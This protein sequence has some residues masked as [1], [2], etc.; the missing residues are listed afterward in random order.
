MLRLSA[1]MLGREPQWEGTSAPIHAAWDWVPGGN[2][3][4]TV[5][6]PA[7]PSEFAVFCELAVQAMAV[8]AAVN[9]LGIT[10][11]GFHFLLKQ[12]LS[13]N[14]SSQQT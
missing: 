1:R 4:G 12:T 8:R 2:L 3:A 7:N 11:L 9:I 5:D 10:A 6:R 14:L 13:I